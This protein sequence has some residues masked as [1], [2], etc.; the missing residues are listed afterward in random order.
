MGAPYERKGLVSN[1]RS[2]RV[3]F[4]MWDL[5]NIADVLAIAKS[6][7]DRAVDDGSPGEESTCRGPGQARSTSWCF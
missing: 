4:E 6:T 5:A 2:R 3:R 7:E 1:L